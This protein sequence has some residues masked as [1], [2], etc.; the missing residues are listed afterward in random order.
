MPY[1]VRLLINV[2]ELMM[3]VS[4]GGRTHPIDGNLLS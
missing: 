4:L 1:P 3:V 2:T